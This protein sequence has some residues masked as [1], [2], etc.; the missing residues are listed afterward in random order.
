MYPPMAPAPAMTIFTR[1]SSLLGGERLGHDAALNLAG[2]GTRN[3]VG[4]VNLLRPLELGQPL[5]AEGDEV[6]LADRLPRPPRRPRPL[7]PRSCAARRS[8]RLRPRPDASSRTSSI[9]RGE[10]FSPPR[11]IS[12]LMRRDEGQIAV[13]VE[14]ALIARSEPAIGERLGV[15]LGIV[16]VPAR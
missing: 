10:I 11:L 2:R 16:L 1:S 4:D 15:R 6:G 8:T 7:R 13:G 9:S 5:L 12:S 14:K 3:G